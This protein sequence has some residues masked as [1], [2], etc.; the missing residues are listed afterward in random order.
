FRPIAVIATFAEIS[1]REMD[2]RL[3]AA[4]ATELAENFAGDDSYVVPAVDWQRTARRVVTQQRLAGIAMDDRDRLLAVGH[5]LRD[6]LE[7]AA[8]I[9][10]KQ[11]F[12]DGYFHGDQHPG[13][14]FVDDQGRIGAVDFGI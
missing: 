9:F 8:A 2:L 12:R 13:N 1:E 7:K 6:I 3:E 4:A 14:M 10:F 5:D 11:A